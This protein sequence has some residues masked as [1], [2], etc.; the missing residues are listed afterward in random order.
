MKKI[1][2]LL[3]PIQEQQSIAALLSEKLAIIEQAKQGIEAQLEAANQLPAA[4]LKE[5]FESQEAKGWE[6]VKLGD[7]CIQDK[8]IINQYSELSNLVYISLEHIESDS[9]K[10]LKNPAEQIEDEGKSTTFYFNENHVLYGKLRPYLNKVALPDFEGRCTTELIPFLAK[11]N[12][13]TREFLALIL[14]QEQ[15][16]GFIMQE[17]TGSRMPRADINKLLTFKM[18]VPP[19]KKQQQIAQTLSEKLATVEQLKTVLNAQ[20]EAINQL[21][22]TLLKQAF[23]GQL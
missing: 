1:S 9:G 3:P 16:I 6:L 8:K 14:R 13:I 10:I 21:P 23:S 12:K 2:F 5:V 15:L 20:L 22:A 11:Y 4:Y 19:I 17:A 18:P 7:I